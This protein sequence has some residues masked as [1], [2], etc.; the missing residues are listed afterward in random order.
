MAV[1]LLLAGNSPL[2]VVGMMN[3]KLQ[4]KLLQSEVGFLVVPE[5]ATNVFQKTAFIKNDC[6]VISPKTGFTTLSNSSPVAIIDEA[7]RDHMENISVENVMEE[8][9]SAANQYSCVVSQSTCDGWQEFGFEAGYPSRARYSRYWACSTISIENCKPIFVKCYFSKRY[10]SR[11]LHRIAI[12]KI[13]M[14]IVR[15]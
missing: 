5:Q 9:S 2:E 3:A 8:N 4:T 1:R 11:H 6:E 7:R 12:V 14:Q 10:E 13:W 15:T